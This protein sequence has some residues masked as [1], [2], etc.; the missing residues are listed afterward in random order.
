MNALALI[1][2]ILL[3]QASYFDMQGTI[4]RVNAPDS[5]LIGNDTINR[6]VTLADVDAS[7]L[8]Q[9]QFNYLMEDLNR[10]LKGKSVYVKGDYVYF[11]LTASYN[12]NS[13]NGM[14]QKEITGLMQM[15]SYFCEN[16]CDTI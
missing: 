4:M 7:G 6:T 12:S 5:L 10:L 13:I 11:E 16:F 8:N 3:L 9:K 15:R 2:L 14:I 1:P